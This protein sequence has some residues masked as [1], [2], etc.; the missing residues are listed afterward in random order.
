MS[1]DELKAEIVRL[2]P[3]T[4]FA[5]SGEFLSVLIRSSELIPLIKSLRSEPQFYFDYLFCLTCIDW[6]D[7]LEMVYHLNSK[8]NKHSLVIKAK[9]SDTIHP[10]IESV[11]GI[12]KAAEAMENEVFDLFGVHFLNHPFQ[13]RLFLEEDFQGFPLRKNYEDENMIKL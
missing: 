7:Y 5:E 11:S 2:F 12:W 6:K 4:A 8:S 3:D 10:E 1:D 13:R 9:I